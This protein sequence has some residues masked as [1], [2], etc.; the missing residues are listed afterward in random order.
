[1]AMQPRRAQQ[2]ILEYT[3]GALAVA[4]VPGAGKTTALVMLATRLIKDLGAR[5]GQLLILT[6]TRSA[7]TNIR[8][9]IRR[10]LEAD[11]I[12]SH[13]IKAVTIHSFCHEVLT[14]YGAR[15][16]LL[17]GFEVLQEREREAIL[18]QALNG[19]LADPVNRRDWR[20]R[21][22]LDADAP[23][24]IDPTLKA[25]ERS[26]LVALK[27]LAVMKNLMLSQV[28]VCEALNQHGLSEVPAMITHYEAERRRRG[29]L[30]YDELVLMVNVLLSRDA[31]VLGRLQ[32]CYRYVLEDE[33]QDSTPGQK[34]LID[35]IVARHGNLVRVGDANQSI[36]ASFTMNDPR[37]FREFC[38]TVPMISMTES[39]RSCQSILDLAN[40]LVTLVARSHPDEHVR[41]NAFRAHL[42]EVAAD[43]SNPVSR[44]G[45]VKWLP[46]EGTKDDE[47]QAIAKGVAQ[48]QAFRPDGRPLSQAILVQTHEQVESYRKALLALDVPVVA[49]GASN[50]EVRVCAEVVLHV[51]RFLAIDTDSDGYRRALVDAFVA[52]WRG[53]HHLSRWDKQLED[54]RGALLVF[55]TQRRV[56]WRK[57]LNPDGVLY[58]ITGYEWPREPGVWAA[59]LEFVRQAGVLLHRR[60]LSPVDLITA[61]ADCY[62]RDPYQLSVA[63][64]IAMMVRRMLHQHPDY[65]LKDVVTELA[66]TNFEGSAQRIFRVSR[67]ETTDEPD[68]DATEPLPVR[69]MTL[70]S[71]KGLEFDCVWLPGLNQSRHYPWELKQA[72]VSDQRLLL[73]EHILKRLAQPESADAADPIAVAAAEQVAERLRLLY[74]GITRAKQ[75]LRLGFQ[76]PGEFSQSKYPYLVAA[77]HITELARVHGESEQGAANPGAVT[78]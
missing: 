6:Y 59:W 61:V 18:Q 70:H 8:E 58:P 13:G 7:A 21:A 32:D 29:A 51:L 69:I 65:R 71:A 5:P 14:R 64:A 78:R 2:A 23:E 68:A 11:G 48:A 31:G 10:A 46:T 37:Y 56:D 47:I 50:E 42:I 49:D 41:Q 17:P 36:Y 57:L 30:D 24:A 55:I 16:G 22:G 73:V 1:M 75:I 43:G 54:L 66:M 35:Q 19:Y 9:R 52:Y 33:A 63:E 26:R 38:E 62:F 76:V 45:A 25:M 4:A 77:W 15:I 72:R 12:P 20:V 53:I 27:A 60:H 67:D 44:R 40:G 34:R 3:G 28:E 74:V 39:S